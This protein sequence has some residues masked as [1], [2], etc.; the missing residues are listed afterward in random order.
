MLDISP[1]YGTCPALS[2]VLVPLAPDFSC[3]QIPRMAQSNEPIVERI[4]EALKAVKKKARRASEEA[5]L[6]P[7]VIR[8]LQRKPDVQPR[9]D[10]LEALSRTLGVTPEWLAWGIRPSRAKPG[11]L[12]IRGE[13]AAG[14]WLELEGPTDVVE[15][16]GAPIPLD[17][18]YPADAQYGLIVRGTSI[19]R[20]AGPGD[21]LQCVDT[22]IR[23]VALNDNDLV[24]VE[25]HRA[26]RGQ[27]EVTAKRWRRRG[28]TI[29]LHPD[30]D[31]PQWRDP[32][33]LDPRKAKDGEEIAV[34]AVVVG[35]YRSLRR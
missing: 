10:T 4:H 32:L 16:D 14:L 22:R 6:G 1:V 7:D 33:V 26:Q 31:D 9:L 19:N 23:P 3:G 15:Y 18:R 24:I 35:L 34:I 29:E 11:L 20:T 8:D 5:G 25:R 12:K 21:V 17:P 13:V 2:T 30:S 27:Q 28:R